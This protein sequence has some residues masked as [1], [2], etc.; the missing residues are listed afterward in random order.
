M[1]ADAERTEL[2]FEIVKSQVF[3]LR[4]SRSLWRTNVDLEEIDVA[5]NVVT[6][7]PGKG[8]QD[9]GRPYSQDIGITHRRVYIRCS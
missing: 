3:C 4:G 7:Q 9:N 1:V 8:V 6:I 2:S 5:Q